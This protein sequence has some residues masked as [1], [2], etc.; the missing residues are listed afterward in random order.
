MLCAYREF[1]HSAAERCAG[2]DLFPFDCRRRTRKIT[3]KSAVKII[4][5]RNYDVSVKSCDSCKSSVAGSVFKRSDCGCRPR[6][7][8]MVLQFFL[9]DPP[10]E[11]SGSIEKL[12]LA[13]RRQTS[14]GQEKGRR[15]NRSRYGIMIPTINFAALPQ[16]SN[17][18][19][20]SGHT[21]TA[22]KIEEYGIINY[23][24]M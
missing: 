6:F 8:L 3:V 19:A 5:P 16:K 11:E 23:K 21:P 7:A 4:I 20:I 22:R 18:C 12:I 15:L 1:H 10:S 13:S 24:R 2:S 17:R 9:S 14:P